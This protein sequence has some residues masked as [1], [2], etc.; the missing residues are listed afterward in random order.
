MTALCVFVYA[1]MIS[2]VILLVL[3]PMPK[4]QINDGKVECGHC[5]VRFNREH[6]RES[7]LGDCY[8]LICGECKEELEQDANECPWHGSHDDI[9]DDWDADETETLEDED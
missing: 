5:H 8:C 3:D 4:R 1:C 2:I 9:D 6:L 7:N